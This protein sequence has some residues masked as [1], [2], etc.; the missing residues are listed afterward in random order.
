MA[1]YCMYFLDCM[2][3]PKLITALLQCCN[4][5]FFVGFLTCPEWTWK[6]HVFSSRKCMLTNHPKKEK[7]FNSRRFIVTYVL[8]TL[9]NVLGTRVGYL[10]L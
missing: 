4:S 9:L 2:H 5:R 3:V 10:T 1:V 7:H 6:F 8:W